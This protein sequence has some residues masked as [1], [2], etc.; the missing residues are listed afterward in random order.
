MSDAV[1]PALG[2]PVR[3]GTVASWMSKLWILPWQIAARSARGAWW[4]IQSALL[5]ACLVWAFVD[6]R[7]AEVARLVSAGLESS[8]GSLETLRRNATALGAVRTGLAGTITVSLLA[9]AVAQGAQW[10]WRSP[11]IFRLRTLLRATLLVACWSALLANH[12]AIT[13]QG[14]RLRLKWE[15]SHVRATAA[16]LQTEW[17][18]EDGELPAW[19]PF[20]AYPIGDPQTLIL[21]TPPAIDHWET[22]VNSVDR[23]RDGTLRFRLGGHPADDWLEWHPSGGV[24]ASFTGG[25]E[26]HHWIQRSASLGDDWYL[27]RYTGR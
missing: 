24:P 23:A 5:A 2:S 27:V 7:F 3:R 12:S 25:L 17:P 26:D 11:R 15:L 19:G 4:V 14:T 21:L 16:R 18:T 22:T 13:W 6:P 10:L 20:M 9:A 8:G 1:H